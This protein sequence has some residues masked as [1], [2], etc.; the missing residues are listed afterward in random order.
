MSGDEF[1]YYG[2]IEGGATHSKM[3]LIRSDGKVAGWSEGPCTNQ[4]LIGLEECLKR[5]NTMTVEVK[6]KAGV[7]ASKPLKA[8]GMSL[9]G[10]DESESQRQLKEGIK[11]N[12][13]DLTSHTYVASDTFGAL[14]TALSNGG[15]VLIAGTGSNCQLIN[16]DNSAYRCGGW[17][18]LIGDESSAYWISHKALKM[19]FDKEDNLVECPYDTTAV[20]DIMCSYFEIKDRPELLNFLYAKF[21]KAK[22]AGMCKELAKCAVDTKD[23]LCLHIFEEAGKLLARHILALG[24]KMDKKILEGDGGLHV[25]CVGSVWKSWSLLEPGFVAVMSEGGPKLGIPEVTLMELLVSGAVGA[26]SL[27]ARDVN[28]DLPM[29]YKANAKIFFNKKLE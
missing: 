12:Y 7:E 19:Y 29:D 14:A 4:W 1:E 6:E 24:P 25:V 11:T 27:G 28:F 20:K 8:L 22:I 9:S 15:I 17:G 16:P 10:G 18:H 13:V 2:G 21:E 3:V 5:I 26:A 23:P